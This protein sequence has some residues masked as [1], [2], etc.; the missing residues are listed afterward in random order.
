MSAPADHAPPPGVPAM[1]LVRWTLVVFMALV[2]FAS[3]LYGVGAFDRLGKGPAG[4]PGAAAK[5]T[6]YHCP[7]HPSI[8]QDHPGECPICSMSLVPFTEGGAG[9]ATP[10]AAAAGGLAAPPGLVPIELSPE[11]IQLTGMR[12]ARVS[13]EPLRT[14]L[15]TP[16][17]IAAS[18]R[19]QAE[20]NTRFAGWIQQLLVAE[21][22]RAVRKG[23]ALA[24]IYSP[25]VLR[26]EQELLTARKWSADPPGA[27]T[28]GGPA[29]L[30]DDAR[31]R[32]ELL[33]VAATDIEELLR[34]GQPHRS[35]TIRSPVS[36][37]VVRKSAVAGTY[38]QP[39]SELY[40]VAD[41]STVWILAEVEEQAVGRVRLGQGAR[42]E[43]PAYPGQT[44]K[45]RVQF[46]SPVVDAG[47]R[48]LRVRV[49]LRNPGGRLKPGMYGSV[50]LDLPRADALVVPTEAVVDTGDVQY[51]FVARGAGRFEPR[52][53]R[54]GA[55]EEGRAQILEGLA[56]GETVVTTANFL[57]D[58]ESRLRAALEGG[59]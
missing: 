5:R 51:V 30:A 27:A 9:H 8:V 56:D 17:T 46:V 41:L 34:T 44:F 55:R 15:R 22:G 21:T 28:A 4:G 31:K 59:R 43:V 42:L 57:I 29:D 45:G 40:A 38:V 14:E 39:G 20:I 37:T 6:L 11:R 52:R 47:S 49:E 36:G 58:S 7:M 18:E 13:R 48:T 35:I 23:E 32:L 26:A 2:A 12:T 3:V 19:G 25:D 53:V 10:D 16:G 50:F 54:V 1:S 33:G 24:T